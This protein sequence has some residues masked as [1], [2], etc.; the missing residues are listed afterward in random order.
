MAGPGQ[1]GDQHLD[2]GEEVQP[3]ARVAGDAEQV[4]V[5]GQD[6][7]PARLVA[8]Q[9]A[10]L[11]VLA[12]RADQPALAAREAV[13]DQVA[14]AGLVQPALAQQREQRLGVADVGFLGAGAL[15]A[16]HRPPGVQRGRVV[17]LAHQVGG[18][19]ADLAGVAV[20][21]LGARPGG[22]QLV[23]VLDVLADVGGEVE[24]LGVVGLE[25]VAGGAVAVA[26][27]AVP[28]ADRGER[29]VGGAEQ[30]GGDPLEAP[31]HLLARP[32]AEAAPVGVP[33][34]EHAGEDDRGLAPLAVVLVGLH[35]FQ[36]G[37]GAQPGVVEPVGGVDEFLGGDGPGPA[38]GAGVVV[39]QRGH[40]RVDGVQHHASFCGSCGPCAPPPD[41][42]AASWPSIAWSSRLM[43][44]RL[45]RA[46][47]LEVSGRRVS[48]TACP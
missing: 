14:G 44:E 6:L 12:D 27:L 7:Q 45:S 36:E 25:A 29:H 24:A 5:L 23:G 33:E 41:R 11:D 15:T 2:A 8:G 22:P 42:P 47:S 17:A 40:H 39:A 20:T 48:S 38:V 43:N 16:E 3:A 13:A 19:G 9:R 46:L 18:R 28:A 31:E 37:H 10:E 1:A 35:E 32:L 34:L 26:H 4:A 21:Q 30:R